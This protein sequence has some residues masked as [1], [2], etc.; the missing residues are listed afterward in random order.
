M[1]QFEVVRRIEVPSPR[2]WAALSD[3]KGIHRF[4]P[5][6]ERADLLTAENCGL[7]AERVCHMY[8]GKDHVTERIVEW[9]EGR[10]LAVSILDTTMPLESAWA[11]LA[12]EPDG[13]A[14]RVTFEM[15]YQPRYG[16]IGRIMDTAFMGRM[17]RTLG[18]QLLAGLEHHLRTGETVGEGGVHVTVEATQPTHAGPV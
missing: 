18:E 17:M 12:V 1:S 10:S 2:V 9:Q 7:G 8:G 11:R 3:F 14:S 4:H 13:A 15:R 6:I 5:R 16:L